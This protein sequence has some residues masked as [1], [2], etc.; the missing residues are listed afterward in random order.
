M[1]T[2]FLGYDDSIQRDKMLYLNMLYNMIGYSIN[3]RFKKVIFARTALEVKSS[4]GAKPVRMFGYIKH[5]N[6]FINYF[7]PQLFKFF[8]PKVSWQERNPFR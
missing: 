5:K 4:V 3:K 7:M 8:E 1:E 6:K 2:Y